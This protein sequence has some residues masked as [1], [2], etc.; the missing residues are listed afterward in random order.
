MFGLVVRF[1]LRPDKAPGFD[2]LVLETVE[3][4]RLQEPGTLIYAIHSVHER[5]DVRIFYELYRDHAAFEAHEDAPH[6][7]RFL[8]ERDRFLA[9]R[10][11]VD[12]LDL[13]TAAGPI[14]AE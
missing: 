3:Q 2:E 14:P 4:I 11:S 13:L 1:E 9:A 8:A 7:R 10:P 12:R 6:T 5:P